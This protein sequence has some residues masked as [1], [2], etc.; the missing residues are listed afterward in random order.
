MLA[1]SPLRYPGGKQVLSR[2][3]ARLVTMNGAAGG[4]YVEPYAGGAGA[5]LSLL[6][7]EHVDRI[8][9]NDAD[10]CICAFWNAVLN[11][12]DDFVDLVRGTPT[13][14]QEWRRQ[15]AVYQHPRRHSALRVGFATFFLNR[16]NR[17]GIIANGG[18]IG[19]LKQGGPWKIDARFNRDTL[20]ERVRQ[21]AMYRD[22]ILV[23]NLDAMEFLDR[24]VRHLGRTDRPFVYLDPP[25]FEKAEDLYM[26]HYRPQ[27]HAALAQYVRGEL[28]HPWVMSYD[29][30]PQIRRLYKG[31][32]KVPFRLDY[33][34]GERRVGTEILIISEGFSLP[35]GWT[36]RIPP[37]E[38]GSNDP[39]L[40]RNRV[41][42]DS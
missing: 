14:V 15:R 11:R 3:L 19:G 8:M 12:T 1:H 17:S 28:P 42:R 40:V 29:N 37:S 9:I 5:A 33:S 41:A 22:R 39:R 32:R 34:A 35:A 30:A 10:A 24:Q 20:E 26:N 18:P 25:Y 21:V 23:S 7:G 38:L 6:M 31:L 16:C 13:T 27:D 36:R 2:V 4:T